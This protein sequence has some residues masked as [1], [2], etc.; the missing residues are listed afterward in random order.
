MVFFLNIRRSLNYVDIYAL[1]PLPP[2]LMW[3]FSIPSQSHVRF[4]WK[5]SSLMCVG[6]STGATFVAPK[7][8]SERVPVI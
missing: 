2:T 1:E 7:R 8:K 4:F 5:E 6:D 3:L